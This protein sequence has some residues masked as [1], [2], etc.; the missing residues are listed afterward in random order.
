MPK[1]VVNSLYNSNSNVRVSV[2]E[3]RVGVVEARVGVVEVRVGVVEARVG[4]VE[5][6]LSKIINRNPKF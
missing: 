4:V 1:L 5:H 2:V 3:A 6:I